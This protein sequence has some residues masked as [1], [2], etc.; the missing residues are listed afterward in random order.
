MYKTCPCFQSLIGKSDIDQGNNTQDISKQ[1]LNWVSQV[2][3]W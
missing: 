1:A 3:Q 2:A